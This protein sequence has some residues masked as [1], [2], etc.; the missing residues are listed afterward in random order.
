MTQKK[1]K[2]V[3]ILWAD[4]DWNSIPKGALR[5]GIVEKSELQ[6]FHYTKKGC[7][8]GGAGKVKITIEEL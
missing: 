6:T 8:E 7:Y 4:A 1:R 2:K 5:F 3:I